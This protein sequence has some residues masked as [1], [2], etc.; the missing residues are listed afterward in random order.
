MFSLI[1][2]YY[3]H[4]SNSAQ[5][6]GL[7]SEAAQKNLIL[8]R[9]KGQHDRMGPCSQ[10]IYNNEKH[11]EVGT[12]EGDDGGTGYFVLDVGDVPLPSLAPDQSPLPDWPVQLW[13]WGFWKEQQAPRATHGQNKEA[14]KMPAKSHE[15]RP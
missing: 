6:I 5:T 8:T 12:V 9:A 15:A 1:I 4:D 2:Y 3:L 14:G 10:A 13:D 7:F 11:R